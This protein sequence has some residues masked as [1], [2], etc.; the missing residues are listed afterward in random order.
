MLLETLRRTQRV[1][2]ALKDPQGLLKARRCSRSL[3]GGL[4]E[5]YRRLETC[6]KSQELV[7]LLKTLR[8]F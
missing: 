8:D 5:S 4:K 2:E 7:E 1:V 3:L 6:G